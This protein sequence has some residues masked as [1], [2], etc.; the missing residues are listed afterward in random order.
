[1]LSFTMPTFS[2]RSGTATMALGVTS[3]PV[4]AV[5]GISTIGT[6]FFARPG[7]SSSSFTPYSSVTS[8]LASFA[9]SITLPPPQATIRSAPWALKSSISFCTVM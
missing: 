1:M 6:H 7:S 3:A 5:V 8:T 4:P 9:A 2:S